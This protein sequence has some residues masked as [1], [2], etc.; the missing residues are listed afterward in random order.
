M[1]LNESLLT[2]K[3]FDIEEGLKL[4]KLILMTLC[5][6][7]SMDTIENQSSKDMIVVSSQNNIFKKIG[8]IKFE[9]GKGAVTAYLTTDVLPDMDMVYKH[10]DNVADDMK[11]ES[12]DSVLMDKIDQ[13]ENKIKELEFDI[14]SK[15]DEILSL[16]EKTEY[17]REESGM[18]DEEIKR[19]NENNEA[20]QNRVTN[21]D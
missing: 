6:I 8:G 18:K 5:T 19:I 1:K 15:K 4:V 7:D 10:E 16:N 14:E 3:S 17:L 11:S 12:D 20:L 13:Y 2:R 9:G 21:L